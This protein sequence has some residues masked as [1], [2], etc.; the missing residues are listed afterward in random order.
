VEVVGL[1]YAKPTIPEALQLLLGEYQENF[2]AMSEAVQISAFTTDFHC[3]SLSTGG[4]GRSEAE[5]VS[6]P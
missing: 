4:G 5:A 6:Q 1:A 3:Q 2:E